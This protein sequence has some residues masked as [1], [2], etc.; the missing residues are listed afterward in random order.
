MLGCLCSWLKDHSYPRPSRKTLP[1]QS[2]MNTSMRCIQ[3]LSPTEKCMRFA[4][5]CLKGMQSSRR[6]QKSSV[7]LAFQSLRAKSC[8]TR[9]GSHRRYFEQLLLNL[10]MCQDT[11]IPL[12]GY[13]SLAHIAQASCQR[14]WVHFAQSIGSSGKALHQGLPN[15]SAT[16]STSIK[17]PFNHLQ[18][19]KSTAVEVFWAVSS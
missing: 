3:C 7:H 16:R 10:S 19:L 15:R 18:N 11:R 12:K 8:L 17:E 14:G 9:R 5:M 13:E 2:T 6:Q 4:S 1:P